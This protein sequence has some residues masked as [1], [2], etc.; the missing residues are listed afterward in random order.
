MSPTLGIL[1]EGHRNALVSWYIAGNWVPRRPQ[2]IRSPDAGEF[3]MGGGVSLLPWISDEARFRVL[4]VVRLRSGIRF[5]PFQ[6]DD[7]L[8]RVRWE[9]HL[10]FRQ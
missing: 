8:S 4:N 1:H 6:G 7:L 10:A 3:S 2:M 5:D 9:F